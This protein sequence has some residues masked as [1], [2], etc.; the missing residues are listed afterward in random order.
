MMQAQL[1]A[2]DV[3]ILGLLRDK[4]LVEEQNRVSVKACIVRNFTSSHRKT[5]N[6]EHL[7]TGWYNVYGGGAD[8]CAHSSFILDSTDSMARWAQ[9]EAFRVLNHPFLAISPSDDL[10]FI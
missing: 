10:P 2:C 4:G 9:K 1:G 7:T 6:Q 8:G 5:G 3:V